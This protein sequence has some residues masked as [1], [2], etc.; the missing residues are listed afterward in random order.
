MD[1]GPWDEDDRSEGPEDERGPLDRTGAEAPTPGE[2]LLYA[3]G[4]L[5]RLYRRGK[6]DVLLEHFDI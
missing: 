3:L 5:Y 2:R 6:L 1:L 4:R